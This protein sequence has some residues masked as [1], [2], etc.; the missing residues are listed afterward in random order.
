[1]PRQYVAGRRVA[2]QSRRDDRGFAIQVT[3]SAGFC[4][5]RGVISSAFEFRHPIFDQSH[6]FGQSVDHTEMLAIAGVR[7]ARPLPEFAQET[8]FHNLSVL[9]HTEFGS[10]GTLDHTGFHLNQTRFDRIQMLP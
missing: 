1:M 5:L 6:A 3:F 10:L 9:T 8:C 4:R 7:A 2:L